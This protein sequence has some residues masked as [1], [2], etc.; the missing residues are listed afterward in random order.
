MGWSIGLF[1]LA[2]RSLC[3]LENQFWGDVDVDLLD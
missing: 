3:F 2:A 1:V